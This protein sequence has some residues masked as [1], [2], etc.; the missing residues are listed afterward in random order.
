MCGDGKCVPGG[1]QCDGLPDCFDKSDEKGCRKSS[2]YSII[3]FLAL[4]CALK[5]CIQIA[6]LVMSSQL[7]NSSR[8][9][10]LQSQ[11]FSLPYS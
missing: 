9:A 7:L 11:F 1:W 4:S 10:V 3:K 6:S 5:Q 8:C 2:L